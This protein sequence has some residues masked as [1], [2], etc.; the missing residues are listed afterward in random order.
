MPP[1]WVWWGPLHSVTREKTLRTSQ[2]SATL[3]RF[4]SG[5]SHAMI[6]GKAI[7][8]CQ[9]AISPP[10]R[11]KYLPLSTGSQKNARD[12]LDV[13]FWRKLG[14]GEKEGPLP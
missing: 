6:A 10:D 11:M 14:G 1:P 9:R 2:E 5:N 8:L 4:V 12:K 7:F 13:K 3:L